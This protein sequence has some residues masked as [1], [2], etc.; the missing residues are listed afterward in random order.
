MYEDEKVLWWMG[1]NIQ[2]FKAHV[3]NHLILQIEV[4]DFSFWESYSWKN[5]S[6]LLN[7]FLFDTKKE[8]VH[9]KKGY[10]DSWL[11][12]PKSFQKELVCKP[13]RE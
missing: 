1:Y 2:D 13:S 8:R 3:L 4:N 6:L 11:T 9:S 12:A 10:S 7:L 5:E